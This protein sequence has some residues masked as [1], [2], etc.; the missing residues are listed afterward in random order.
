[1]IKYNGRMF[2]PWRRN[3][4]VIFIVHTIVFLLVTG[5]FGY[6]NITASNNRLIIFGVSVLVM[7]VTCTLGIIFYIRNIYNPI[8]I[9]E[10]AIKILERGEAEQYL[11]D[12]TNYEKHSNAEKVGEILGKLHHSVN[13]QYSA[14]ILKNQAEFSALQSQINPHFLYNTLESIRGQALDEG[15]E[16]IAEMTEALATFFRYSISKKGDLVTLEDEFNN[17]EN[18][19]IIQQYRFENKFNFS[20]KYDEADKDILN[21]MLPKLTIQP[22]VENS[23]FHGLE[24]K[25]GKG[26]ISIRVTTTA[27]RLIISISDDGVGIDKAALDILNYNMHHCLNQSQVKEQSMS[28]RHTGIAV[29]NVNMRI[30]LLFGDEYGITISSTKGLGTDVEIILALIKEDEVENIINLRKSYEN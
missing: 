11:N 21:Y 16:E 28:Q 7:A 26:N 2:S 29:V 27:K 1:M 10:T 22:I 23:I 17:V 4:K 20:I 13:R 14:E 5:L 24:T 9:T 3:L 18:Y 19:F 8:V 15:V 12:N 30:K 6:V 25:V